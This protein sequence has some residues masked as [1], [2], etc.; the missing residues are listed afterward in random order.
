MDQRY[1]WLGM[2]GFSL[3]SSTMHLNQGFASLSQVDMVNPRSSLLCIVYN[4]WCTKF[5]SEGCAYS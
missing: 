4:G 3:I 1:Y 5:A 2:V